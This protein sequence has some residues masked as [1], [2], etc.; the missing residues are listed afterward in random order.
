MLGAYFSA[1]PL[2]SSRDTLRA[3]SMLPRVLNHIDGVIGRIRKFAL[4]VSA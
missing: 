4:L 3:A 2:E 1:R